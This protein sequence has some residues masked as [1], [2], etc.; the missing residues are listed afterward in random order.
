MPE[1]Q[2]LR[3]VAYKVR[4][5]DVL[6]ANFVDDSYV[7]YIRLN[8]TNVSRVNIIATLIYKAE[9]FSYASAVIDDG[10]GRISLRSFENKVIFSKADVGDVVLVIGRIRE[11]NNE[12]YIMP[13][14]LKKI[15]LEW[16]NVRK[17]ELIKNDKIESKAI[18]S[19]IQS[20]T[21]G[22]EVASINEEIYLLIKRLDTGDGVA[23]D[24]VIK[25]FDN[26]EAEKI[27]NILLEKGDIFEVK[28]GK[29][30]VLE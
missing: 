5:S 6:D 21:L 23:I 16:M 14:V 28:P 30:K 11:F 15:S 29:L 27:L 25:K 7:R 1:L 8:N 9:D 20:G 4:I 26:I 17:L 12:K 22:K 13:E 3:Q 2:K 24:D 10:T 19:K 18:S